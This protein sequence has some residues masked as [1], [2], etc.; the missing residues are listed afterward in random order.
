MLAPIDRRFG[1]HRG[2]VRLLLSY[3]EVYVGDLRGVRHP[4]LSQVRRLVFVCQGN[5]CRSCF[6]ETYARSLG[7]ESS[8]CGL[9]TSGGVPA[10]GL[11][12]ETA[13]PFG[14]DLSSHR[15]RSIAEFAFRDGDLL[16]A[17]EP[18]QI[19]RLRALALPANAQSSLLGLWAAP[20]RPHIHDPHTL[21]RDYFETCFRVVRGAV[22]RLV[23]ELPGSKNP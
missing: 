3:G 18:R 21:G 8:S 10:F 6:A 20:P 22:D 15:S 5:I 11:A 7:V 17:M 1:T 16:L 4:V 2:L 19:R 23:A 13:R 14:V 9:A 12:I